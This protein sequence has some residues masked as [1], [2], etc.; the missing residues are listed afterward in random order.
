MPQYVY[1]I[2]AIAIIVV[3]L[4][5]A[6]VTF[7]LY[8]KTPAPKGCENLEPDANLCCACLKSGCPFYGQYHDPKAADDAAKKDEA[9]APKKPEA[10]PTNKPEEKK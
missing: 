2:I 10:T 3:L 1:V 6:I 8:R 5:V 4:V 7:V 9:S